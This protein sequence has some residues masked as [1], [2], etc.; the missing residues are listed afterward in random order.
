M[1]GAVRMLRGETTIIEADTKSGPV[2]SLSKQPPPPP[3]AALP[4]R[5]KLGARI[6]SGQFAVSVELTAPT[7]LDLSRT[8]QQVEQLIAGGIDIINIADGPRASAR[9]ANVAVC[10][11]LA[12]ETP[13]EPILHVC[14][15]DRSFLGLVAHLIGA[16]ALGL[17]DLVIITGDPPKMGDY[18]FS[19]PVYDVDSVGLLRIAA[20]LNAG[21]DPAGKECEPT[22]FV[23]AT[24]AEPAAADRERELRRLE[25]K[26]TAGAELVMTQPVY[27]PRTLERFLDDVAPLGLPVMVGTRV[28]SQR[29]VPPQRGPRHEHP[30]RV[31]R[32]DGEGR[33]GS[34]GACGRHPHRAGSTRRREASRGRCVRDAAVQPGRRSSRGARGRARSVD[35]HAKVILTRAAYLALLFV[36]VGTRRSV[37]RTHATLGMVLMRQRR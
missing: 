24:G 11:R 7:G 17:R 37:K 6:A 28:A 9:M 5:S 23:L 14:A 18:P 15:R 1:L 3:R 2:V 30:R 34:R 29:R 31:S 32:P 33:R 19:T 8:K 10:A 12:A 25:D 36:V 4:S 35:S 16:H 22:S 26:K 27:D 21:V 20:G 13:V